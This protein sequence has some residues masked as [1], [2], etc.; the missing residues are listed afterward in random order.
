MSGFRYIDDSGQ[1]ESLAGELA[2]HE[3]I[4]LDTEFVRERTYYPLLCLIQ[5]ASPAGIALIDTLA[6]EDLAPLGELLA[7]TH[8]TKVLHAARQDMEIL[9]ARTGMLP[10]P[11]FDTQ[12]ATALLGHGSQVSYAALVEALLGARLAKAHTRTDWARRPL[13]PEQQAYAADDVRYLLP[14]ETGLREELSSRGRTDWVAAELE[15]LADE[16]RYRTDPGDAWRRLKGLHRLEQHA[17]A[18]VRSLAA[19]RERQ[20][21]RDDRPRQWILRDADLLELARSAPGAE[22]ELA[23]LGG[24]RGGFVRRHGAE[25]VALIASARAVPAPEAALSL[26]PRLDAGQKDLLA[27]LA[28]EVRACAARH[29]LNPELLATRGDLERLVR[30]DADLAVLKGWRRR[31]IGDRLLEIF[32]NAG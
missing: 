25:L 17:H 8:V 2:A 12:V 3:R 16:Q 18:L 5:V 15:L 14:L 4:A 28:G 22:G 7:D 27:R 23:G 10:R 21:M 20:A 30:G 26:P 19:W 32:R 24:L 31:L 29:E 6:V 13:S 11:V 9:L 1:L